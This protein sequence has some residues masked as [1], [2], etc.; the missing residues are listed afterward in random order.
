[1]IEVDDL[2]NS[3]YQATYFTTSHHK[4]H[5]DNESKEA[6]DGQPILHYVELNSVGDF[7][8][9]SNSMLKDCA[10]VFSKEDKTVPRISFKRDCDGVCFLKLGE[11]DFLLFVEVKTSF[12]EIKR[13]GFEQLV[14]SYVKMRCLLNAV[15]SYQSG[16]YEEKAFLFSYP[17]EEKKRE[18]ESD[19]VFVSKTEVVAPT[20]IDLANRKYASVLR[21]DGHVALDLND[22]N[23]DQCHLKNSLVNPTL[24]VVYLK[25]QDEASDASI[26]IDDQL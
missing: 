12:N 7:I 13:K 16:D 11:R 9:I 6:K 2:R 25:V 8:G 24:E 17:F 20:K 22:Y 3:V 5:V 26:I 14:A 4:F 23:V 18:M 21:V 15:S 19:D 10:S 1:M